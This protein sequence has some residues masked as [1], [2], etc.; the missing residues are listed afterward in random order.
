MKLSHLLMAAT[1][2]CGTIFPMTGYGQSGDFTLELPFGVK[3]E[4]VKVEAGS[5]WMGSPEDEKG[6]LSNEKRHWVTLTKD[7]YIGRTEVTQAQW[8]EVMGNNPSFFKGDNRPVE[9]VSWDDAMKFCEKLNAMG[10]APK[11]WKFILP[12]EA[13]WEYAARG[14]NKSKRYIY[15]GSNTVEDVAWFRGK[16]KNGTSPVGMKKA[17]ELGLYDMSGNVAEWCLDWYEKKGGY[18][19]NPETLAGNSGS[20]RVARGGS[21]GSFAG[22]CRSAYRNIVVPGKR[23][24]FLGFRLALVPVQ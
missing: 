15:S 20:S 11:G 7:F 3:L 19:A 9:Q 10:K 12:T 18:A 4:M 5:F 2:A 23:N 17:N 16:T 13:Q 24:N 22:G 21:W 14:G 6:H 8:K 1:L